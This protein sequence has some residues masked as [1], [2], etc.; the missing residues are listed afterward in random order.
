[1]LNE[2][3]RSVVGTTRQAA[4]VDYARMAGKFKLLGPVFKHGARRRANQLLLI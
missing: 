1:M 4:G 3:F 2:I